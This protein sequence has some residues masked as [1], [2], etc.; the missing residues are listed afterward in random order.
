MLR[1]EI[2]QI[3]STRKELKKFGWMVGI[4]L[5][6][7]GVLFLIWEKESAIYF[8]GTGSL[9]LLS[10]L[11]VPMS[12]KYLHK[13][14]MTLTIILAS[15]VTYVLLGLLF[16][17]GFTTMGMMARLLK[18]PFLDMEWKEPRESYWNYREQKNIDHNHLEKQY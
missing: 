16:Y 17:L 3:K 15:V 2:K 6:I 1:D 14:W 12:L 13:V 4:A 8:L 9:L 7:L 10:G 5:I 18:K 11:L